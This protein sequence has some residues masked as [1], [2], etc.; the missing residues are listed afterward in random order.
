M[1]YG[2]LGVDVSKGYADFTFVDQ[3]KKELTKAF[4]LMDNRCGHDKLFRVIKEVK[5]KSEL[6]EVYCGVESTGGYENNW[7][8]SLYSLESTGVHVVRIN[9]IRIHHES[10][11][12][13]NRVIT[14]SEASN[15]IA[16]HLVNSKNDLLDVPKLNLINSSARKAY[17]LISTTKKQKTQ[18]INQ[19]E[20]HIYNTIPELISLSRNGIAKWLL[21]LLV[22][23]PGLERLKRA[24]ISGLTQIKGITELK[25]KKIK[26][27]I[28]N[29]I[30]YQGDYFLEYTVGSLAKKIIELDTQIVEHKKFLEKNFSNHSIELMQSLKG[31]GAYTAIGLSCEFEDISRFE[32]SKKI[33]SYFGI[34]PVFKT[35]GDGSTK[36]RMSKKGRA[37][38]RD[39]LYMAARNVVLHN[40]YFKGIYIAKRKQGMSYNA[41]IGVIMHKLLRVIYGMLKNDTPFD[42]SIDQKNKKNSENV[43]VQSIEKV[44]ECLEKE[45]DEMQSA[46]CSSRALNRK[47]VN[48]ESQI[49]IKDISTR[50]KDSPNVKI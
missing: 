40:E 4:K 12:Q 19:L 21:Q 38:C 39:L 25:A 5:K 44:M 1:N 24:K 47:K 33:C 27:T 13:M 2:F 6:R 20:K 46:P 32:S 31:I 3:D 34:H 17:K 14:D 7:Y 49:S 41:A 29:S 18:L 50:S 42:P 30:G 43:K 10:K 48:L 15:T 26:K 35:S 11:T 16:I 9:P 28:K 36:A 8:R 45:Y 22:R 23:Y 37:S